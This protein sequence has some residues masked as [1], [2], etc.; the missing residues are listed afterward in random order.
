MST[1]SINPHEAVIAS[2]QAETDPVITQS[3]MLAD[4][5]ETEIGA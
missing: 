3:P 1:H 4:W 5:V 2:L